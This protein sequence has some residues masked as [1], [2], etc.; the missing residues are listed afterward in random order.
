MHRIVT[1]QGR[2][3]PEG[4]GVRQRGNF[5]WGLT[6]SVLLSLHSPVLPPVVPTVSFYRSSPAQFQ[7]PSEQA[8]GPIWRQTIRWSLATT[9]TTELP[10]WDPSAPVCPGSRPLPTFSPQLYSWLLAPH[11]LCCLNT[12]L[13]GATVLGTSA[14]PLGLFQNHNLESS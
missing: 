4:F 12:C 3:S 10:V 14:L 9:E 8:R 6:G 7:S 11:H 2:Y 1:P 5:P 13:E